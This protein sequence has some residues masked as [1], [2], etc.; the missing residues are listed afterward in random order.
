MRDYPLAIGELKNW[1][2]IVE[3]NNITNQYDNR[4]TFIY[5]ELAELY[6]EL[7]DYGNA[8]KYVSLSVDS[9][10]SQSLKQKLEAKKLN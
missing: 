2:D 6:F 1:L 8:E 9:D 4:D 3:R 7:E 5:N 10:R